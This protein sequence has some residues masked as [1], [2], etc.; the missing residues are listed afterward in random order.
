MAFTGFRPAAWQFFRGL[1]RNNRREWFEA[2][3]EIYE[4]DVRAPLRELLGELDVRLATLAPGLMPEMVAAVSKLMRV[5]DLIAVAR[6]I[7]VVTRFR[8]TVGLRGRLA[9]RLPVTGRV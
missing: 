8:T 6:K 9:T 2:R 3:R 5:Q 4:A 7:E 1:K